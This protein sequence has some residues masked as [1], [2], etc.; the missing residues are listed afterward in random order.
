MIAHGLRCTA[1]PEQLISVKRTDDSFAPIRGLGLNQSK[2]WKGLDSNQSQRWKPPRRWLR[3]RYGVNAF[4]CILVSK[5]QHKAN[6]VTM[7]LPRLPF[8]YP[9]LFNG[10]CSVESYVLCMRHSPTKSFASRARHCQFHNIGTRQQ[11]KFLQR[12]GP[13]LE[14]IPLGSGSNKNP[15]IADST[16]QPTPVGVHNY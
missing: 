2:H 10:F 11:D 9:F 4:P 12:Y 6:R 5:G 1:L 14:P 16:F 15:E 13:A 7:S 3:D 8:L